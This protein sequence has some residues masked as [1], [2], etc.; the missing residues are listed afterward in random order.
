MP[1]AAKHGRMV[2][3]LERHLLIKFHDNI[4]TWSDIPTSLMP[5]ATKLERMVSYLKQVLP[6]SLHEPIIT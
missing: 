1:M 6:L 4:F 5:M 2:T 3:F